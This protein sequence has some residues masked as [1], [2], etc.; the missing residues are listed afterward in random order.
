MLIGDA[1]LI[2]QADVIRTIGRRQ[3]DCVDPFE[4]GALRQ[5]EFLGGQNLTHKIDFTNGIAVDL[6]EDAVR[7]LDYAL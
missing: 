7:R 2:H 3:T 5:L 6:H 1:N 4:Q